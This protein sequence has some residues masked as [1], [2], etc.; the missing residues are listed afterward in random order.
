MVYLRGRVSII[1]HLA[2]ITARGASKRIPRKNIKPFLGQPIIKYS[3]DAAIKSE[4]FKEVMVST[5]DHE[6]AEL[7]KAYGAKVPFMRSERNSDDHATTR[8]VLIEVLVEYKKR[9]FE[10]DCLC[11]IYPT[12][13][14][15]TAEKLQTGLKILIDSDADALTPVTRFSYPIQ[16]AFKIDEG[17]LRYFWPEHENERSQDLI[18]FYHDVGQFYWYKANSFLKRNEMSDYKNVPMLIPEME[19]QDLDTEEDWKVAEFKYQWLM[20][21]F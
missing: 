13:P 4:L 8:D 6:I 21:K 19:M 12:A 3:I 5:D 18:S 2:I 15:V 1:N 20:N 7:S 16:R 9:G 14:F 10:F 17:R 11:C